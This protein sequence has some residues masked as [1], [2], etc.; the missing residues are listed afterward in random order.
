MW[1]EITGYGIALTYHL[2]P[3]STTDKAADGIEGGGDFRR[4]PLF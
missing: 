3:D 1:I 4:S 2:L